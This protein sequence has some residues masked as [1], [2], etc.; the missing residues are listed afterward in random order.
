[1]VKQL[2]KQ[3]N[4]TVVEVDI[5]LRNAGGSV[6]LHPALCHFMEDAAELTERFHQA[7]YFGSWEDPSVHSI[8]FIG[9]THEFDQ[10]KEGV[11]SFLLSFQREL[12]DP[13]LQDDW[14]ADIG[15]PVPKIE[16]FEIQLVR[17]YEW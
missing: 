8:N 9:E 1:M 12:E 4:C 16:S 11:E 5:H 14:I 2:R 17:P 7:I 3:K 6:G 10:V 13:N 15:E